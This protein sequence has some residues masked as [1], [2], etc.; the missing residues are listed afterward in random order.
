[1]II[2]LPLLRKLS[3]RHRTMLGQ[4]LIAA[5]VVAV[6][7]GIATAPGLVVPGALA[8]IIGAVS[9]GSAR[10]ARRRLAADDRQ[11]GGQYH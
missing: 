8:L 11:V 10:K 4:V 2:L 6:L 9:L 5:G 1:M 3:I 7:V